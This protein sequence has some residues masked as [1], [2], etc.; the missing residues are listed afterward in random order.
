MKIIP[1]ESSGVICK[2][3]SRQEFKCKCR[4]KGCRSTIYSQKLVDAFLDFRA[5]IGMPVYVRSGYRC[6]YHNEAVGG[7]ELSRH[8]LGEA[9]DLETE[10]LLKRWAVGRILFILKESG[11][12]FVKHYPEKGIIHADVREI[13]DGTM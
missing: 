6:P 3:L 7:V 2:G 5:L 4:T 8:Q 11:F 10:N 13:E 9:L 1:K 12:T